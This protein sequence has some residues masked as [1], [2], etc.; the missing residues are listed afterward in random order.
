MKTSSS[1]NN[2]IIILI[3]S[4]NKANDFNKQ[5]YLKYIHVN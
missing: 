5:I 2:Q 3:S 4:N 1:D